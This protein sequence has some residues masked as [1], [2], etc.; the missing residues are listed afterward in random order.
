MIEPA[1]LKF[2]ELTRIRPAASVVAEPEPETV[3]D[4]RKD[5]FATDTALPFVSVIC[6]ADWINALVPEAFCT[7]PMVCTRNYFKAGLTMMV[8]VPVAVAP[9]SSVTVSTTG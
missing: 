2:F 3:P 8:V 9:R 1:E 6:T 5:T 7:N 4:H